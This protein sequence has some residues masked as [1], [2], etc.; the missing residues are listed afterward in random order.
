MGR[1]P[2]VRPDQFVICRGPRCCS[3]M[4]AAKRWCAR[5]WSRIPQRTRDA[6]VRCVAFLAEHADDPGARFALDAALVDADRALR[7]RGR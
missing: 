1:A 4:A 5:C 6:V 3:I 7:R 2:R